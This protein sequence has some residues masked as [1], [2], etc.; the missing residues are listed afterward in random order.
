[1]PE[2]LVISVPK[3]LDEYPS[4]KKVKEFAKQF[5]KNQWQTLCSNKQFIDLL[6]EDSEKSKILAVEILYKKKE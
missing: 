6:M 3:I 2:K 4:V 1:M 5:T